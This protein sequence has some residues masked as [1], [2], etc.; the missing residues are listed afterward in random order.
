MKKRFFSLF[1][2]CCLLCALLPSTALR[3]HAEKERIGL[4]M[5]LFFSGLLAFS[6]F[7]FGEYIPARAFCAPVT[8]PLLAA[9]LLA[10]TPTERKQGSRRAVFAVLTFCFGLCFLM[11]S[12][13]ILQ[14][15]RAAQIR[16][17]GFL[18]AAEGD[19]TLITSPYPYRTK[20][21]AQYGNP[22]LAPDADWPNGIMA[23]YYG[24]IRII[25][26]DSD[27]T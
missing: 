14:V 4:A 23:D 7:L 19:K 17:E 24:I 9:V 18:K 12:L 27:A 6:L 16:E 15:H 1:L 10:E 8:L 20:Y 13:D 5:I 3:I 21:T 25:V 22:D 11:G 2:A 26:V